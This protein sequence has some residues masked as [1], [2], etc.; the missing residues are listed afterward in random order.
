MIRMMAE[1]GNRDP[2]L[3]CDQCRA[4]IVHEGNFEF[5]LKP[6]DPTYQAEVFCT[7]K[8]CSDAFRRQR[9]EPAGSFWGCRE[10]DLLPRFLE[11]SLRADPERALR[12]ARLYGLI[13]SQGAL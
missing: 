7:H 12:R 11:D 8:H 3:L 5:L 1:N 10:L 4:R 13:P 2:H 9:P 6:D